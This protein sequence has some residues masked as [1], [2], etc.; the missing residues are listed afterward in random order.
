MI[1]QLMSSKVFILFLSLP[2]GVHSLEGFPQEVAKRPPGFLSLCSVGNN[3]VFSSQ[4]FQEDTHWQNL[5]HKL[6]LSLKPL[7]QPDWLS[8]D[9]V[10]PLAWFH[11]LRLGK[12][13]FH[14]KSMCVCVCVC[15][16][17]LNKDALRD[18]EHR[19]PLHALY[20]YHKLYIL[21]ITFPSIYQQHLRVGIKERA[22]PPL[23]QKRNERSFC[24]L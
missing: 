9:F 2:F 17:L 18:T 11:G 16:C 24:P 3:S 6:S 22:M 15:V 13:Q 20:L 14:G 4:Q 8:S 21:C 1:A 10:S 5:N 19:P 7:Y 12:H 23:W